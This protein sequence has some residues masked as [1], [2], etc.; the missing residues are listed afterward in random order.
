[1]I[2]IADSDAVLDRERL[3]SQHQAALTL[4]QQALADPEQLALTWL[5][6]ACGKGQILAHL[7]ENLTPAQRA[8]IDYVGFDLNVEYGRLT[9]KRA[10]QLGFR[11]SKVAVGELSQFPSIIGRDE[12]F[13]FITLTNTIHEIE[14][15]RLATVLFDCI[16]HLRIDGRFFVY[17]MESLPNPELGAVPWRSSEI[18]AILGTLISGL[19]VKVYSPPVG[20]WLHRSCMGWNA[21]IDRKHIWKEVR[22]IKNRRESVIQTTT[23]KITEILHRRS[24]ECA[25]VL[26]SLTRF[27]S[28]TGRESAEEITTLYEF[29]ALHRALRQ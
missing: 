6:L 15:S 28:A 27:G 4:L 20:R 22:D 3:L 9:E 25:N 16:A 1:M 14:P 11:S 24:G 18:S 17:D 26:E 13:D 7:D 19:G 8:K 29:W 12:E 23:E 2:G 5:D 10:T 21:Q